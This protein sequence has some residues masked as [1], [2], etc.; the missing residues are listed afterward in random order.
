L[1]INNFVVLLPLEINMS[2]RGFRKFF[3]ILEKQ[4]KPHCTEFVKKS[5]IFAEQNRY[6]MAKSEKK[7]KYRVL[8]IAVALGC[9]LFGILL[10][11]S[12]NLNSKDVIRS[13]RNS[14]A[15][16]AHNNEKLKDIRD[17]EWHRMADVAQENEDS[18]LF[19]ILDGLSDTSR[20]YQYVDSL[21][22][23][24]IIY[25]DG[26]QG[27]QLRRADEVSQTSFFMINEENAK[28]LRDKLQQYQ[29]FLNSCIRKGYATVDF[30]LND[31]NLYGRTVSW[32]S[33]HFENVMAIEAVC[34]LDM[35]KQQLM[36]A[37]LTVLRSFILTYDN[38][39]L[40]NN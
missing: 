28:V 8:C 18:T 5:S 3:E 30:E 35:I 17:A 29:D 40:E 13:Y 33:Y 16:L 2:A 14:L 1:N 15:T 4:V 36:M 12:L 7:S 25:V 34:Q 37:D 11:I 10:G 32:E 19:R 24:L 26:V 38:P 21:R 39:E 6:F 20:I 23:A 31:Q 27:E 22:T 9:S